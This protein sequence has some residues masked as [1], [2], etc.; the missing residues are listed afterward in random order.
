MTRFVLAAV[1]GLFATLLFIPRGEQVQAQYFTGYV[2]PYVV[3]INYKDGLFH[4]HTAWYDAGGRYYPAGSYAWLNSN[5][6]LYGHGYY[7]PAKVE[8]PKAADYTPDWKKKLLDIAAARDKVEGRLRI[9]ALDHQTYLEALKALGLEGNFKWNGYGTAPVYP[10]AGATHTY[11]YN[12]AGSVNLGNF[13]A[14]G[15]TIYGYSYSSIKDVYGDTNLNSLYQQAARLTQNAQQLAGQATTDFSD[16]VGKEGENRARVAE[17]LAKA[18]A[19]KAA[20][21]AATPQTR[22]REESRVF[23]FSAVSDGNGGVKVVP[24][25]GNG[26]AAQPAAVTGEAQQF[27][28]QACAACHSGANKKGGFDIASY[29]TLNLEQKAKVWER[30]FSTDPEKVMPR[31]KDGKPAPLPAEGKKK[32]VAD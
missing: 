4:W 20:L 32:F 13:G 2:T 17:I 12:N 22:T 7:Y 24:I 18:Q 11:G 16:L 26:A 21:D 3:P 25:E 6:Y 30:V 14:N 29:P 10:N 28:V 15:N 31:S 27:R 1:A 19:A 23:S 8:A 9:Q 5:W